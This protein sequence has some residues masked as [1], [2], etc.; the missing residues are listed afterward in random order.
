MS[1]EKITDENFEKEVLKSSKPVVAIFSAKWCGPCQAMS[2]AYEEISKELSEKVLI[3]KMDI[4]SDPNTPVKYGIR[5][6]P[7]MLLFSNSEIVG[8]KIGATSKTNLLDW[9]KENI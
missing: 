9:I 8:T 3:K 2:G 7:S 4:D 5:G 1:V 6:V